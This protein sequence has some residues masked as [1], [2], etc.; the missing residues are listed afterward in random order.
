[1]KYK[2]FGTDGIRGKVGDVTMSPEFMVK[3]GWATGTVLKNLYSNN[4]I[5]IGK[6]TR[7]SGYMFESALE[8]GLVAAGMNVGLL[9]PMPTPAISY[10]TKTFRANAGI[11]I[12]ASHNCF[13]D[14]GIKF[15][16]SDGSKLSDKICHEIES[17]LEKTIKVVE[18]SKIGKAR[19][20]PGAP[21]RYIEFCKSKLTPEKSLNG[22]KIVIDCA[23]GATYHIAENVFVELGAKVVCINKSPNGININNNCGSTSPQTIL[24]AQKKHN[25]DI[26]IA[27]DGDGDRL[28]MVTKQGKVLDGDDILFILAKHAKSRGKLVSR[29]VV[30]TIMSN[31]GLEKALQNEE[32]PFT[33][34]NVGDRFVME[35]LK[36]N[37]WYLGGEPSGHIINLRKT[38]T[39]DGIINAI[40]V[41]NSMLDN[42]KTLDEISSGLMKTPQK[43][44]NIEIN[45]PKQF[46]ALKDTQ[47]LIAKINNKI[48]N[49]GRA[50]IRASGTESKI[51]ILVESENKD[52]VENTSSE[53]LESIT[54]IA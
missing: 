12:S 22:L 20:I 1:M 29:G 16:T 28:I 3:L 15:F 26:G 14:N 40:L 38:I 7:I 21:D 31:Y 24:I 8:S 36:Q 2:Y 45:N 10:L 5:I 33:R 46:I 4:E 17:T 39:G 37:N 30:G 43:L 23:N 44:T 51:R 27:F 25:A 19:R 54:E 48:A 50:L 34:V 9:G 35:K 41:M 11:V 13:E 32:I 42:N 53:I 52:I 18:P 6:D 49:K 47:A